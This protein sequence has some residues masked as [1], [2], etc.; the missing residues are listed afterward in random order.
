MRDL[1]LD[2]F[3]AKL[4]IIFELNNNTHS[5]KYI[6]IILFLAYKYNMK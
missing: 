4:Q 5:I 1:S 6:N 3:Y 2:M